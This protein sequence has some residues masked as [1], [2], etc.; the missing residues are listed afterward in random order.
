MKLIKRI[1]D[2][3]LALAFSAVCLPVLAQTSNPATIKPNQPAP[4]ATNPTTDPAVDKNTH[5]NHNQGTTTRTDSL[6]TT[7]K[8]GTSIIT[9]PGTRNKK[10]DTTKST[11]K[12][13]P[14][15]QE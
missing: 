10:P 4:A 7:P 1:K 5:S 15:R 3:F 11:T 9:A 13:K 14:I 8:E 2:G 12:K 6:V